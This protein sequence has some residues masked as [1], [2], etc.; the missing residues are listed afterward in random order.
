MMFR[1]AFHRL[2]GQYGVRRETAYVPADQISVD[3]V[4]AGIWPLV[5]AFNQI[6]GVRTIASCH[7]HRWF[8]FESHIG[9]PYVYFQGPA[10]FALALSEQIDAAQS[11]QVLNYPWKVK[12]LTHPEF[13]LSI[14]LSMNCVS[15]RRERLRNDLAWMTQQVAC[16]ISHDSSAAMQYEPS[17]CREQDKSPNQFSIFSSLPGA[18]RIWASATRAL[19]SNSWIK[20]A[21][22]CRILAKVSAVHRFLR[23]RD[24]MKK[25]HDGERIPESRLRKRSPALT[26]TE[27]S[28]RFRDRLS[29]EGATRV[30]LHL[31]ATLSSLLANECQ[32]T[33]ETA[34]EA[35]E[36]LLDRAL[37]SSCGGRP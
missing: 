5:Q 24:K 37:R 4:E 26:S 34:Q 11:A 1:S 20:G 27:R 29:S 22:A 15:F 23:E 14:H 25:Q 19:G 31:A 9:K 21:T 30:D 10:E 32:R 7:G 35:I 2:A 3:I 18:E 33:G 6:D 16:Q 12:G 36:R 17:H 8:D 28:R 13:G